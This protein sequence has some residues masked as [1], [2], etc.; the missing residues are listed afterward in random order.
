MILQFGI[1]KGKP[2]EEVPDD[3]LC[4]LS[5]PS[6]SSKYYKN[7][8]SDEHIWKVPF[9]I[10]VAARGILDKRGWKLKGEHWE[11]KI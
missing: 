4:W 7:K 1:Y 3:Y 9:E 10:K 6:Y 11:K 8:Y 2:L 5:K